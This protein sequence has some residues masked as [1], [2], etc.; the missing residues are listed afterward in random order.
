MMN[1]AA[2]EAV[3]LFGGKVEV[4]DPK[5]STCEALLICGG[6]D[7]TV[8]VVDRD[9]M[10][11]FGDGNALQL[12]IWTGGAIF[13]TGAFWNNQERARDVVQRTKSLRDTPPTNSES[14]GRSWKATTT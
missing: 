4:R 6:K 9:N 5:R 10:G 11:G 8:Y 14:L 13:E 2:N 1:D 3:L 7:G 12:P